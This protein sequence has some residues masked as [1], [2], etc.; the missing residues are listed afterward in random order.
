MFGLQLDNDGFPY[1]SPEVLG[2]LERSFQARAGHFE[3][4]ATGNRIV[5]VQDGR[6]QAIDLGETSSCNTSVDFLDREA[7]G[8]AVV[9][10]VEKLDSQ[11]GYDRRQQFVYALFNGD[12]PYLLSKRL[13]PVPCITETKGVGQSPRL[14]AS[15]P[16]Y[17]ASSEMGP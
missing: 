7:K 12:D 10:D 13:T 11:G 17:R 15:T 1:R 8:T 9:F 6:D 2:P 4:V 3:R 14:S 16:R 5:L